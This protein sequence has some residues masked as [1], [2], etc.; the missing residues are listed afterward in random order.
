MDKDNL[1][2]NMPSIHIVAFCKRSYIWQIKSAF[3]QQVLRSHSP[4]EMSDVV[5]L[6][7]KQQHRYSYNS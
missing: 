5:N 2:L 4:L 7:N 3:R 1:Y 6:F